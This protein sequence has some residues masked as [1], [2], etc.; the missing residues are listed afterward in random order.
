MSSS[1]SWLAASASLGLISSAPEMS[2]GFGVALELRVSLSGVDEPERQVGLE[3][4][5]P[6]ET[7][8]RGG[9]VS[10]GHVHSSNVVP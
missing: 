4:Q 2:F 9:V 8:G 5:R 10:F 3:R 7:F 6:L 1:P